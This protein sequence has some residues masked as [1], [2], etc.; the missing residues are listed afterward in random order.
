M[1]EDR[2]LTLDEVY[3][4]SYR[5][6]SG[7][8]AEPHQAD[9]GARSIRDAEADG[10]RNVGLGYLPIYCEH[11]VCGKLDGTA[12]PRLEE[13]APASLQVDAG[14]GFSHAAFEHA[15]PRF[16][17]MTRTT[18]IAGLS[19]VDSTS[20]GVVA[21]FVEPLAEA[22]LVALA[23]ANSSP[24]MAAHGGKRRFFGTNPI[25]FAA[26]RSDGPPLVVDQATSQVAFVRVRE[27]A[28]GGKPIPIGWGLDAEGQPT[29]D[30][31]AVVDGG[32]MAPAGGA[33]GAMLALLVDLLAGGIAGPHF[34]YQASGFTT[35]EGP[36]PG[37]G[38]F[39]LAI[40]PERFAP[41]TRLGASF[42]ERVTGQLAEMTAEPGSRLPGASRLAHRACAATHGVA[43]PLELIE[44]LEGFAAGR[45]PG[46]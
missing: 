20:A 39:I 29:T 22:G 6:L 44:R 13:L 15:L 16:I 24:L 27:A 14:N 23:F 35:N 12:R 7:A 17:A 10:I 4:L 18:G 32:S 3:D 11:L 40:D 37:V 36:P 42:A 31:H 34:S 1:N 43:V 5:A 21:W 38:Q 8:G 2:T 41:A 9:P 26:P 46:A 19:I 45:R 33:K 25:A 30:P 28:A